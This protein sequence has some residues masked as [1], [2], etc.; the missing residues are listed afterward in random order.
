MGESP[1]FEEDL[2]E[3]DGND[4][5]QQQ[6]LTKLVKDLRERKVEGLDGIKTYRLL[7][8]CISQRDPS[9]L[10]PNNGSGMSAGSVRYVIH[11]LTAGNDAPDYKHQ[12]RF[13]KW[14][15]QICITIWVYGCERAD[16]QELRRSASDS[17]LSDDFTPSANEASYLAIIAFVL[18]GDFDQKLAE[19]VDAV[20]WNSK[21]EYAC[22]VEPLR[23]T[24]SRERQDLVEFMR[25]S[26]SG[27]MQKLAY[28]GDKRLLSLG[29]K[30]HTR[31]SKLGLDLTRPFAGTQDFNR[32]QYPAALES[33]FLEALRAEQEAL[34]FRHNARAGDGAN[35][36][37]WK[38]VPRRFGSGEALVAD[39][40][41]LF[42]RSR[43]ESAQTQ[44][45]NILRDA[46]SEIAER[47]RRIVDAVKKLTETRSGRDTGN[48][49]QE[50]ESL[51]EEGP[52]YHG[53]NGTAEI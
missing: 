46:M 23:N 5:Q 4:P 3:S 27:V 33:M 12:E 17:I 37:H 25:L 51:A 16:W 1:S 40:A 7:H 45:E 2:T 20:V 30:L 38:P 31:L 11:H 15:T 41:D 8:Q 39:F 48:A 19:Y 52:A 43:R 29:Q 53:M 34:G 35:S 18:G 42:R 6:H 13:L 49:M 10:L 22:E 9:R 24:I 28:C 32:A 14:I 21:V 26:F 44:L 50:T 36:Q 47:R